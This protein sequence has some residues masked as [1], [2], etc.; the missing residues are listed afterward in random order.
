MLS[1]KYSPHFFAKVHNLKGRQQYHNLITT[2]RFTQRPKTEHIN[3]LLD[4]RLIRPQAEK[5]IL[6]D[7]PSRT[8]PEAPKNT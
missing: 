7:D 8:S 3:I 1:L 4:C 5:V 2:D 6:F